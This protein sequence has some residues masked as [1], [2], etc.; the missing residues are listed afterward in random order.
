MNAEGTRGWVAGDEGVTLR[1]DGTQWKKDEASSAATG[2]ANLNTLWMNTEGTS[3]WATGRQG[4]VLS[5]GIEQ[6]ERASIDRNVDQFSSTVRI[7]FE[8]L[9]PI[10]DSVR[11]A[12]LDEDK[13]ILVP[14]DHFKIKPV[15]GDDKTF[16]VSFSAKAS[17]I[18]TERVGKTFN[19]QVT[20]DF[21]DQEVPTRITFQTKSSLFVKGTYWLSKYLYLLGGILFVNVGLVVASVYSTRVRRLALDPTIRTLMG[22]GIFRYLV[23]EP[24]LVYV[25]PIRNALF[26]DFRRQLAVLPEIK[27][28]DSNR[29]ILPRVTGFSDSLPPNALKLAEQVEG[30]S[31]TEI[32][33]PRMPSIET[34]LDLLLCKAN[35]R[36]QVWLVEGP[37]GLGKSAFLQQLARASLKRGA[38]PLLIRSGVIPKKRA[39]PQI[40]L[41]RRWLRS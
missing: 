27:K 30:E 33:T 41:N 10:P 11:L 20:A 29:Y 2:F 8:G 21:G 24:L 13:A 40:H 36:Q 18:A 14:D 25:R 39:M 28:W 26:R 12:V 7:L 34:I 5:A 23:T 32:S 17:Q 3:G 22:I 19:L 16:E 6:K 9:P 4:I 38:T 15:H 37:S 1:Y 31:R 35:F